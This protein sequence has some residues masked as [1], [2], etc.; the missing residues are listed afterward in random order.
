MVFPNYFR[1][2]VRPGWSGGTGYSKTVDHRPGREGLITSPGVGF[3]RPGAVFCGPGD[4][5]VVINVV[6]RQYVY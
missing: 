2:S 4:G 5:L 6:A 1:P 3:C